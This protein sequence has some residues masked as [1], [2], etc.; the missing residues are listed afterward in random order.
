MARHLCVTHVPLF[1]QL[2]EDEQQKIEELVRH[3][4]YQK[5]ELVFQPGSEEL[6]IVA[7][8]SLRVYQ[9]SPSGKEQL[10]R[11]VRPGGYEGESRLFGAGNDSLFGEALEESEVC[12]LSKRSFN[13]MLL[14]DPKIALRLFELSS[15]KW[16]QTERQVQLVALERVEQRIAAYLLDLVEKD[17]TYQVTLP[18][19]MKDIAKYL[20]TTPEMLSRKFRQLEDDGLIARSGRKVTILDTDALLDI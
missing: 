5:G 2:P 1:S 8:G 10:L 9:L 19:Q 3:Q 14:K 13:Q 17:G 20:G 7:R 12:R 11:V 15:Q 16:I 18:L 4:T 6:D